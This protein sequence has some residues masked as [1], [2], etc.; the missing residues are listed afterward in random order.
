MGFAQTDLQPAAIVKLTKSE[1]ITVKQLRTETEKLIR[2]TLGQTLQRQPTAAEV[3][4]A[5][6]NLTMAERRQVLDVMINEKLALQ[7]AERDKIT[8]SEN[9]INQQFQRLRANMAQA[10][11]RQPTDDEFAMA[12]KNQTG[13][14]LSAF[15]DQLRRQALVQRYLMSKKGDIIEAVRKPTDAEILL[16]YNNN[17]AQMVRPDTVRVSMIQVPFGSSAA[18]RTKARD[19][20]NR[21]VQEIGSNPTKFDEAVIKSQSQ[22][23]GYQ[24]GDAGYLPRSPQVQQAL[25]Q[26]LMNVAFSLKQGEISRLV[27]SPQGFHILKVTE[28]YEMK[29]L[30]L[31]DMIQPGNSTTVR[32]YILQ[33]LSQQYEEETLARASQELVTELRKGNPF[34]VFDNNLNW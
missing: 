1:P 32:N 33:G 29:I 2:D 27:E 8:V 23:S 13:Q 14:D 26:E 19:L 12:I 10:S 18:D 31:N 11:G 24:G 25:G 22:G 17:K 4:S 3:N 6:Q 15:R 28:S 20:A 7:A 30:E 5:V 16:Y 34:Q 9:E 21:L